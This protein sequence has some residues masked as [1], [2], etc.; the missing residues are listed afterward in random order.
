MR[1]AVTVK[2]LGGAKVL[3]TRACG[4][5]EVKDFMKGPISRRIP[6]MGLSILIGYWQRSGVYLPPCPK[7][8]KSA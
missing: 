5:S 2:R 8:R 6:E 7:C 1:T 4:H 3:F